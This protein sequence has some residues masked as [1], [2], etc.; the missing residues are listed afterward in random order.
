M[1]PALETLIWVF[2]SEGGLAPSPRVCFLGA[3]AHPALAAWPGLTGWQPLK[4]LA[5]AWDRAGFARSDEPPAGRWPMVLVLPGKSRDE[6]LAAFAMARDRLEPGGRIVVAIANTAG[7]G[8][9]EKEFA[10]VTGGVVS[11]QKHKCRV[12]HACDDGTWDESCFDAWRALSVPQ[13]I[14]G[15]AFTT[16]A[17]VFSS[18]HID[19]GSRLLADHLPAGLR[20]R[21]AD[22]GAGWGFLSDALLRR[23]PGV[24]A[25]D[26]FEADH[27]ALGCARA[28]LAGRARDC[29][30]HWHDVTKGLSDVY[31]VIVMNPPFHS[32]QATDVGLG[33]AFIRSAAAALRRGGRLLLVANRQLP[34][35]SL[36][37]E[38]GLVWRHAGG[39]ATYKLL[40]AD[41]R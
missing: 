39:D 28:N 9:F 13:A 14:D 19:P 3:E 1:N 6:T 18:G 25:V 35:E 8:R 31:D 15:T 26:L 24:T 16:V 33:R 11:L 34:Y 41:K 37:D 22:L 20:G 10:R 21:A 2:E 7:A 30:F 36:L 38:A 40:F 4:P 12:F 29:R 27:R 5:D 32:G 23:C 17:G